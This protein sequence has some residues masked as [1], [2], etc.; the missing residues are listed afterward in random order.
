MV[1]DTRRKFVEFEIGE[2]ITANYSHTVLLDEGIDYPL[3]RCRAGIDVI[4]I[5]LH[6]ILATMG[7]IDG[8]VPASSDEERLLFGNEVNDTTIILGE[9]SKDLC[10]SI[11]TIIIYYNYVVVEGGLLLKSRMYSITNG[12]YTIIDWNDY[13]CQWTV[14]FT[15][16]QRFGRLKL[17]G[18]N[19]P[20]IDG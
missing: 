15:Y 14:V 10:R 11:C 3:Q 6:N 20:T 4:A 17:L 12:S 16:G 9:L 1:D 8:F 2:A 19:Q 5:E 7:R 13:A 18:S